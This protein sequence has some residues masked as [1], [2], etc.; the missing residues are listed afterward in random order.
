MSL[1]YCIAIIAAVVVSITFLYV[2]YNTFKI[3]PES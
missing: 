1:N 2:T 3:K